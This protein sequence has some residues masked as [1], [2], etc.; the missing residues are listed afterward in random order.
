M[1][2]VASGPRAGR[3]GVAHG[4]SR[5][6]VDSDFD[7]TPPPL[8]RWATHLV[9]GGRTCRPAFSLLELMIGIVILGFG[10]IMVATMFPVAWSRA[11]TLS[12]YTVER[13][14]TENAHT[15]VRSLL[16][17]SGPTHIASSFESDLLFQA[18]LT[19]PALDVPVRPLA[20]IAECPDFP[21]DTSV[22]ALNLENIQ[23]VNRQ[24]VNEDT[25]LREGGALENAFNSVIG[26]VVEQSFF[27]KRIS[28]HERMFP[29]M[30]RRTSNDFA[31]PNDPWDA[32]LDTRRFCW[33]VLYRLRDMISFDATTDI[34]APGSTRSFD[35]Y[36]VTLR[37]AQPAFR[38]AR[39]KP[40]AN[41][42][43]DPCLLSASPVTPAAMDPNKDVAFPVPWRVQVQFTGIFLPG[44]APTGIP[45]EIE[46]PSTLGTFNENETLMFIQMFQR[47]TRFIDEINGQIYE[48][49]DQRVSPAADKATLTLDREVL[50]DDLDMPNN[51]LR[52]APCGVNM[53]I[54]EE[55][56]RTVW[57]FPPPVEP[58]AAP[59]APVIFNG[60]PPAIAIDVRTLSV[61]PN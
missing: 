18:D 47:G 37:R 58:R 10:L 29:P 26:P 50:F 12:Q 51:D 39:Q 40:D 41:S 22:H 46:V 11:R 1:T 27:Y 43:P 49:I 25:W 61:G 19:V 4:F 48:V 20:P 38:Y 28:F 21:S 57:V 55:L 33:S 23:V 8:K 9:G 30:E 44:A 36:Y 45:T 5:G 60:S 35:M 13:A 3:L 16:R 54:P 42:L 15:T 14:I 17:T 32:A 53:L 34:S 6:G 59:G 7:S 2:P 52:C 24:F 56:L 31:V